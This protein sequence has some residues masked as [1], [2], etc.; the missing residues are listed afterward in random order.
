MEGGM[1]AEKLKQSEAG[2]RDNGSQESTITHRHTSPARKKEQRTLETVLPTR[3][4]IRDNSEQEYSS[5][6]DIE[7]S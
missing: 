6:L 3:T 7:Y 1:E 2:D 5:L 4:N